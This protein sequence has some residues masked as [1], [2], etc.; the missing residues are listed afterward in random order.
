MKG[1]GEKAYKDQ[2]L[3]AKEQGAESRTSYG[4]FLVKAGIQPVSDAVMEYYN[5]AASGKAGRKS[6]GAKRIADIVDAYGDTERACDTI[7]FITMKSLIDTVSMDVKAQTAAIQIGGQLE[8]ECRFAAFREENK[9]LYDTLTKNLDGRTKSQHHKREVMRRSMSKAE[10]KEGTEY[11]QKW[12]LSDRL[13]IGMVLIEIA[14]DATGVASLR[15]VNEGRNKTSYYIQPTKDTLEWIKARGEHDAVLCPAWMPCVIPP[16]EWST[17]YDGGYHT[18]EA[19]AGMKM[20][21]PVK[22]MSGAVKANYLAEMAERA[23]EMPEVYQ[24]VNAM[25]NTV[26]QINPETFPIFKEVWENM[27]AERRAGLPAWIDYE[28]KEVMEP[29]PVEGDWQQRKAWKARASDLWAEINRENSRV[30]QTSK[31]LFIAKKLADEPEICFPYQLDFRGRVYS[32]P[33]MLHP[34]GSDLARGLLRFGKGKPLTDHTAYQWW[35]IHGANVWGEDKLKL[36]ERVAWVESNRDLILRVGR[37]PIGNTEWQDADSPW[38]ALAW[39]M[40]YARREIN[41]ATFESYIPVQLDG[42]CNGLQHFSA[43]LRDAEGG[44][45]TNLLPSDR[46][47]DIYQRVAD[48]ATGKLRLIASDSE[49]ERQDKVSAQRWMAIGIDRKT[50]KRSVMIRPYG[51]TRRATQQYISQHI[52]DDRNREERAVLNPDDPQ[53]M[54]KPSMFLASV[55]YEALDEIV[56]ASKEAMDWL[57]SLAKLASQEELP[58]NWRTLVGMYVMQAYPNIKMR[59]V[60]T[61]LGDSS[62]KLSVKADQTGLD[63]KKQATGISPNFVHSLDAAALMRYVCRAKDRGIDSFS[64]IHDSYGTHAADTQTSLDCLRAAFV[65]IYEKHDPLAEFEEDVTQVLS[66]KRR[67]KVPERPPKGNLD[68]RAVLESEYFFA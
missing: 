25:Q 45:A 44:A 28:P 42:S 1:L 65:D 17:P 32:T 36:T 14:I 58:V 50:T 33:I 56:V 53:D 11:F 31:I 21:K 6:T 52:H 24:S 40:E 23:H 68:I 15:Q 64:L 39:S 12:G 13:Q 5:R 62:I 37:D 20:I 3:Q 7:A 10:S 4:R 35:C 43:M 30:V 41:P 66:D 59:R 57:Q 27:G 26:W 2:V 19:Q 9:P 67:A 63:K 18:D 61:T 29:F 51:G 54:W 22:S 16:R 60:T 34:Q 46:P 49:T 55:V 8:D 48:R 38:Q 47:Q